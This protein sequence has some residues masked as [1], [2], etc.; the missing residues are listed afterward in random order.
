VTDVLGTPNY[1]RGTFDA[2]RESPERRE[3]LGAGETA[4]FDVNLDLHDY[5]VAV[6]VF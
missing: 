2:L 6:C 5:L 3:T 1:V 4:V